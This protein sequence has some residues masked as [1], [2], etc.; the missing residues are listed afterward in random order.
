MI[1]ILITLK[2]YSKLRL[3][4]ILSLNNYHPTI[5]SFFIINPSVTHSAFL[6]IFVFLIFM[7]SN[8]PFPKEIN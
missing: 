8:K 4:E 1:L 5:F 3:K 7:P 2:Y 6:L